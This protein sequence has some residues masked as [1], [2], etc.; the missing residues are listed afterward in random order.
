M[1]TNRVNKKIREMKDDKRNINSIRTMFS[2]YMVLF[3]CSGLTQVSS[4]G[5]EVVA[6]TIQKSHVI[7]Q[8]KEFQI[9]VLFSI[10]R[11]WY[12]YAPT[13]NNS[14]QG[15]IETNV[16]LTLP[17][18]ITRAGKIKLPEPRF[19]NGYEVYEGKGITMSQV[20]QVSP[21]LKQGQYEIKG[22]VMW[23]T[24]NSEIC[25]PPVTEEIVAVVNVK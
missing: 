15:M 10:Q 7:Q 20:L 6:Y 11:E 14:A 12:I 5:D 24:C 23:Q 2:F 22:R 3:S 19:K 21:D 9:S 1:Q 16:I 8:G 13:G 25:L 18:G 4:G 17:K